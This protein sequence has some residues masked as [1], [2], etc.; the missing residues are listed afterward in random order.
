MSRATKGLC[1]SV[2]L[3]GLLAL[4]SS[5]VP[6]RGAAGFWAHAERIALIGGEDRLLVSKATTPD[7]L[8]PAILPVP[9]RLVMPLVRNFPATIDLAAGPDR[10]IRT[11]SW[12]ESRAP[13]RIL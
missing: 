2:V 5:F 3:L 11:H 10:I 4:L 1:V 13:P 6:E 7:D 8:P 9:A 12:P